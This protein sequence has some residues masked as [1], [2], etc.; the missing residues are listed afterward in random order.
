MSF[1]I[2][3]LIH[4]ALPVITFFICF[5][6]VRSE[7]FSPRMGVV[8]AVFLIALAAGI[9]GVGAR[10]GMIGNDELLSFYTM[11]RSTIWHGTTVLAVGYGLLAFSIM[12]LFW[13][14]PRKPNPDTQSDN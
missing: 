9:N 5:K 13:R 6:N 14:A 3:Q 10:L 4:F 2:L 11:E 1:D 12:R 8:V 7:R